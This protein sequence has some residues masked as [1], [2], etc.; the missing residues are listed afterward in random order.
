MR[1]EL[2]LCNPKITLKLH[3]WDSTKVRNKRGRGSGEN[4]QPMKSQWRVYVSFFRL[5]LNHRLQLH[6][7]R[8]RD[9]CPIHVTKIGLFC[10]K[11]N[12]ICKDELASVL[13]LSKSIRVTVAPSQRYLCRAVHLTGENPSADNDHIKVYSSPFS[14]LPCKL[15]LTLLNGASLGEHSVFE[16]L[17]LSTAEHTGQ[18]KTQH[19]SHFLLFCFSLKE[20]TMSACGP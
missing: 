7:H 13:I 10:L 17:S 6:A 8:W 14:P 18:Q 12:W 19:K 16:P 2:C 4:G 1:Y 9:M 11:V 3:P 15:N 20:L 5:I